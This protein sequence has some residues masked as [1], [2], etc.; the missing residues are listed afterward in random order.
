[1]L[2]MR[3]TIIFLQD[4]F[5]MQGLIHS[6]FV[7]MAF[8]AFQEEKINKFLEEYLNIIGLE[9]SSLCFEKTAMGW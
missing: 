3:L 7:L 1:L 5:F 2:K 6:H 4:H 8:Y 9:S